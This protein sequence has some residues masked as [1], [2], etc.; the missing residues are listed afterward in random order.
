MPLCRP[1]GFLVI[2]PMLYDRFR[3]PAGRG[4]SRPRGWR[5]LPWLAPIA[6]TAAYF[7]VH[8]LTTAQPLGAFGVHGLFA[9]GQSLRQLYDL[10]SFGRSFFAVDAIHSV[11]GSILDRAVFLAAACALPWLYRHDRTLFWFA[12]PLTVV[13]AVS[14][15]FM[16][17][18]RFALVLFPVFWAL[19]TV[20]RTHRRNGLR[21]AWLSLSLALQGWLY[22]RHSLNL[23]AG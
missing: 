8:A 9:S 19:A 14:L 1:V 21:W 11:Q 2:V 13:P 4:A 18:T 20:L 6:G 3:A 5:E 12:L 15:H 17:F 7:G 23:W 10:I 22:F 16:A